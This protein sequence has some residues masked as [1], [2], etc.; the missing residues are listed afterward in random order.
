MWKFDF[1][2]MRWIFLIG[3]KTAQEK[4]IYT[5]P[6]GLPGSRQLTTMIVH[7]NNSLFLHGGEGYDSNQATGIKYL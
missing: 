7:P 4:G 3:N 1:N 6:Y 5:T 2:I